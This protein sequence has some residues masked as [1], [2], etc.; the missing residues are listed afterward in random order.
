MCKFNSLKKASENIENQL[1][2]FGW[3]KVNDGELYIL[4][5]PVEINFNFQRLVLFV[6]PVE[7]GYYV[8]DGGETFITFD[9]DTKYYYDLFNEYDDNYHFEIETENE[10]LYKK[11]SGD[12]KLISAINEF[13]RF[14]IFLDEF[15]LNNNIG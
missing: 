14:F 12:F 10:Y 8:F 11:Y 1:S 7:D 4:D 9:N 6:R 3:E 15:M 2:V 13:T 5:L